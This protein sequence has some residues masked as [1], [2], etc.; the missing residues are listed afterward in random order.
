MLCP[1]AAQVALLATLLTWSC[2]STLHGFC[3]IPSSTGWCLHPRRATGWRSHLWL[4]SAKDKSS[5]AVCIKRAG[6][7]PEQVAMGLVCS[8]CGGVGKAEPKTLRFLNLFLPFF[9][10]GFVGLLL[11]W[12]MVLALRASPN[13]HDFLTF[14]GTAIGSVTGYYFGGTKHQPGCPGRR[15]CPKTGSGA[16]E[17]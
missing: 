15:R 6:L 9:A 4:Q 2:H 1:A 8:V 10:A 13:F 16:G 5:C 14:A 11:I 7:P 12:L 3:R 17:R